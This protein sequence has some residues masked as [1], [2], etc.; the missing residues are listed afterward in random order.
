M[1]LF[2]FFNSYH[3]IFIKKIIIKLK[4]S[5]FRTNSLNISL[6]YILLNNINVNLRIRRK[7]ALSK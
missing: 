1:K 7:R 5:N 2:N 4:N 6:F 3:I